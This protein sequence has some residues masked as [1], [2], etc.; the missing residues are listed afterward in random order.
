MEAVLELDGDPASAGT[1]IIGGEYINDPAIGADRLRVPPFVWVALDS[2]PET[3]DA[4]VDGNHHNPY[5]KPSLVKKLI[6]MGQQ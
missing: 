1:R 3:L 4:T 2:G 5:V 6:A